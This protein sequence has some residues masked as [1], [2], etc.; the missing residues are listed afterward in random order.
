MTKIKES[1]EN[2]AF[3]YLQ[4]I[5]SLSIAIILSPPFNKI[6]LSENCVYS[7]TNVNILLDTK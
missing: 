6:P 5:K 4:T 1:L 3:L 7:A 2:D